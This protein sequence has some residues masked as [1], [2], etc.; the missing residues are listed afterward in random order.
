MTA[1][2]ETVGVK[3]LYYIGESGGMVTPENVTG[4]I[5]R[6]WTPV[7]A[8]ADHESAL[9]ELREEYQQVRDAWLAESSRRG[10]YADKYLDLL[11]GLE[12]LAGEWD[13]SAKYAGYT[14]DARNAWADCVRELRALIPAAANTESE[15]TKS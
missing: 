15:E 7:I 6:N 11:S 5:R 9:A 13:G 12:A 2:S 14:M 10:Y 8:L 3:V 4:H 1:K